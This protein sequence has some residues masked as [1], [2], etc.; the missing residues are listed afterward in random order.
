MEDK[1]AIDSEVRYSIEIGAV[2][3]IVWNALVYPD[4]LKRWMLDTELEVVSD[5]Q[6][7]RP[8]VFRGAL[9]GSRFENRGTI[10][11][12]APET[13]FEYDYWSTLSRSKVPDRP[14]NYTT[15]RFELS[16]TDSGTK[17]TVLVRGFPDESIY[18][19]V[20]FYWNGTLIVLKRFCEEQGGL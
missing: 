9:N 1:Y 6:V 11:A 3:S 17:L 7:G 12:F 18:R 13:V 16:D 14:E 15:V 5:W 8:I 4:S 10:R 19:H 2:R 20:K